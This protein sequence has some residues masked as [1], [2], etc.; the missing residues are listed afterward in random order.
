VNKAVVNEDP[1]AKLIRELKSE[2]EQL[3]GLSFIFFFFFFF[4]SFLFLPFVL[5]ILNSFPIKAQL[6]NGGRPTEEQLTRWAGSD[7]KAPPEKIV[8]DQIQASEKL[9]AE[10]NQS[11]EQKIE[12]TKEIQKT[13]EAAL[14][15]MGIAV[16]EGERGAI[17]LSTPQK[18]PH[19]INLN[20]DPLISECLIYYIKDGITR[21]GTQN[22][23][24]RFYFFFF[25]CFSFCF[26]FL[27]LKGSSGYSASRIEYS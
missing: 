13:R 1:N 17:G 22:A 15:E 4:S 23:Q 8:A 20:E 9:M 21:L 19:L 3:R 25:F 27:F 11:W 12:R 5:R 18:L 2:L 26:S 10:L 14:E 16:K 6:M 24:V 7:T